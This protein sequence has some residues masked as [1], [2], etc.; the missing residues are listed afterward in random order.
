MFL[1]K[2]IEKAAADVYNYADITGNARAK[3]VILSLLGYTPSLKV[4]AAIEQDFLNLDEHNDMFGD[5][6]RYR[7]PLSRL[8]VNSFGRAL[9]DFA[10]FFAVYPEVL[11]ALGNEH[12]RLTLENA[13]KFIDISANVTSDYNDYRQQFERLSRLLTTDN[14]ESEL[15]FFKRSLRLDAR[16]MDYM[17]GVVGVPK[18]YERVFDMSSLRYVERMSEVNAQ[19]IDDIVARLQ[20]GGTYH[21]RGSDN[22]ELLYILSVAEQDADIEFLHVDFQRLFACI[23]E[24]DDA[25][26]ALH[27]ELILNEVALCV[28]NISIVED[29]QGHKWA[30]LLQLLNN[31]LSELSGAPIFLLSD[32]SVNLIPYT[33]QLISVTDIPDFT[34][35][36][37]SEL[38]E[39]FADK[40]GLR[41]EIDCSLLAGKY[42]LSRLQTQKAVELISLLPEKDDRSV[43][44]ACNSV[45][46]APR[47]GNIKKINASYK[48]EQLKLHPRQRLAIENIVDHVR[49]RFKVYDTWGMDKKYAYGKNVSA[50]FVGPPGTGKTMAVH[51]MSDM[52]N[53]PLYSINLSQVVDKYVGET[54][55][56][57]EE[58]FETAE[59]SNVILFFD[60]ADS[61]FGKR[62]DITDSKDKYANSEV[63][64]ILQ[65]L[66]Q[67]EGIVIL[68]TNL[69]K[70]IDDAFLRR[71]RYIVDF[72]QPTPELRLEIWRSVFAPQVPL[73][74][75]DFDFLAH[76]FELSGGMIKNIALNATFLAAADQ[77]SVTMKHIFISIKNENSKVGKTMLVHDFGMYSP[78]MTDVL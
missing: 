17:C 68:A 12:T 19:H 42:M 46:P 56:R 72:P 30:F 11:F 26:W 35:V 55:K 52:L 60:E 45:I 43:A 70:N 62:S 63:S 75:P 28:H 47:Q 16:Y 64:Y 40:A 5:Y 53:L 20:T 38:F 13:L 51:V 9:F 54:E 66:E 71:M 4:A 57:L 34:R 61:I 24:G 15:P 25:L 37:R 78:L 18:E 21:V 10:V 58:I 48:L 76:N 36:Q 2:L 73:E 44:A 7:L 67:Y 1:T 65:R 3:D 39:F 27:R 49:Y 6:M 50:L 77:G 23:K 31:E 29:E 8:S 22:E 41:Q 59:K 74:E 14:T 33:R 32:R 69:K